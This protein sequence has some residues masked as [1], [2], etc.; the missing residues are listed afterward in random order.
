MY[1]TVA[2]SVAHGPIM[3]LTFYA[4]PKCDMKCTHYRHFY[5]RRHEKYAHTFWQQKWHDAP[6]I[7]SFV[8]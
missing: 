1:D 5:S 7:Q 4:A 3:T 8:V 6:A 2:Q